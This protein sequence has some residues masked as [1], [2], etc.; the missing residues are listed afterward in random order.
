M[1]IG[2]EVLPAEVNVLPLF[3]EYSQFVIVDPPVEA[4]AV[5]ATDNDVFPGVIEVMDGAEGVVAG[6][7]DTAVEAVPEPIELTARKTT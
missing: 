2:D 6:V 7:P 3:V 1:D 5:N 4:G